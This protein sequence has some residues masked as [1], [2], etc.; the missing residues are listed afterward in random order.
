MPRLLAT[1]AVGVAP[2]GI[3][4]ISIVA[5]TM[6]VTVPSE[7][8]ATHAASPA[9]ATASG[10]DPTVAAPVAAGDCRSMRWTR[11]GPPSDERT[12]THAS[13]GAAPTATAVPTSRTG[14]SRTPERV[15][16][17]VVENEAAIHSVAPA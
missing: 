15:S 14:E 1:S 2:T 4:L 9:T 12:T 7:E 16:S 13:P 3:V 8:L 17:G 11:H 6:R 5:R 10:F